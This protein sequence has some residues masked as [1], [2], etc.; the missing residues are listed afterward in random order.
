MGIS[1]WSGS[2]TMK[3]NQPSMLEV[4]VV[5]PGQSPPVEPPTVQQWSP[6]QP[7][8]F[9]AVDV[10]LLRA[11]HMGP[12]RGSKG[13]TLQAEFQRLAH[14]SAGTAAAA[15]VVSFSGASSTVSRGPM[16]PVLPSRAA[17]VTATGGSASFSIGRSQLGSPRLPPGYKKTMIATV[18]SSV[19]STYAGSTGSTSMTG[20]LSPQRAAEVHRPISPDRLRAV[21]TRSPRVQE[22]VTADAAAH[23]CWHHMAPSP[24]PPSGPPQVDVAPAALQAAPISE[25]AC[26]PQPEASQPLQIPA[27][28]PI[29][30]RC[31]SARRHSSTERQRR[32]ST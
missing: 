31:N 10:D 16:T 28:V 4:V 29:M 8:E 19:S 7:Q 32:N 15:H 22:S 24:L 27:G 25:E 21:V 13:P 11:A 3:F 9:Q 26:P 5:P 30:E 6:R 14:S 23:L 18:P 20:R 1:K 12:S 17:A 2:T